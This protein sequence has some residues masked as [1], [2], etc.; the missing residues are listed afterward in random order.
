M[1][2]PSCDQPGRRLQPPGLL[3]DAVRAQT[4]TPSDALYSSG[5]YSGR[6][7]R[8]SFA[9]DRLAKPWKLKEPF[10]L[11]LEETKTPT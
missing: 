11:G 10:G 1:A 2:G 5:G 7:T 6:Y 3:I 4:P 9:R 8:R